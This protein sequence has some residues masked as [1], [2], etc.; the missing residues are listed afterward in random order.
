MS[1]SD[2]ENENTS[3]GSRAKTLIKLMITTTEALD[4]KFFNLLDQKNFFVPKI[5]YDRKKIWAK[6]IFQ[7]KKFLLPKKKF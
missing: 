4:P 3:P 1:S 2:E 7:P 5:F 6:K